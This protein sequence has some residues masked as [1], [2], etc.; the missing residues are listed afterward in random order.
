M[1]TDMVSTYIRLFTAVWA[2]FQK[3][4]EG[5]VELEQVEELVHT[6]LA[7]MEHMFCCSENDIK[8]HNIHHVIQ[9]IRD[10]GPLWTFSM[11]RYE[12]I[13]GLLKKRLKNMAHPEVS[14]MHSMADIQDALFCNMEPNEW[15]YNPSDWLDHVNDSAKMAHK[16]WAPDLLFYRT[17]K[18]PTPPPASHMRFSSLLLGKGTKGMSEL[19]I[20]LHGF[21][22]VHFIPYKVRWNTYLASPWYTD[23]VPYSERSSKDGDME[24]GFRM[25]ISDHQVALHHFQDW[26]PADV[27]AATKVAGDGKPA[28]YHCLGRMTTVARHIGLAGATIKPTKTESV[29]EQDGAIK[30]PSYNSWVMCEKFGTDRHIYVGQVRRIFRHRDPDGEVLW[31]V[32]VHKWLCS[33]EDSLHNVVYHPHLLMPTFGAEAEAHTAGAH[34]WRCSQLAPTNFAMVGSPDSGREGRQ[35]VALHTDRRFVQAGGHLLPDWPVWTGL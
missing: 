4:F 18:D 26:V 33:L 34:L 24:R 20:E 27:D 35:W 6:A 23:T 31:Y 5:E 30:H 28:A 8:V 21:F 10:Q 1:A 11:W 12:H 32:W 15:D 16:M 2:S 17:C 3:S 22:L 14:I 29:L 9:R 19:A 25:S 7:L 13:F